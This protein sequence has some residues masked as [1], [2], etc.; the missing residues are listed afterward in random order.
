MT[1][2]RVNQLLKSYRFELGRCGHIKA[3]IAEL[4][5][6]YK[7]TEHDLTIAMVSPG[8]QVI[9]D[10]PRGTSV[11]KP[12]EQYAMRLLEGLKDK[13]LKDIE[14]KI[15]A[16]KSELEER[17]TAVAYVQSWLAGLPERE[18]WVIE[19]QVIDG[20]FWKD[21]C[22]RYRQ[23]FEEDCSKD[24]LKRCRDRALEKIYDMAK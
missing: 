23:H 19:A 11:G 10:M 13:D 8:A 16:L 24:T 5:R 1:V 14:I 17:S 15:E 22:S 7:Q 20:V 12:T 4:E 18:R 6:R 9:S 3:E 21:V 2:E